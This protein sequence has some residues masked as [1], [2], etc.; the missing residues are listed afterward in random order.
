MLFHKEIASL[1]ILS[2]VVCTVG[3]MLAVHPSW[4][5]VKDIQAARNSSF[6]YSEVS[7]ENF[8]SLLKD[9]KSANMVFVYTLLIPSG[10]ADGMYLDVNAVLLHEVPPIIKVSYLSE[11]GLITS[12]VLAFYLEDFVITLMLKQLL[13][14]LGHSVASVVSF[15]TTMYTCQMIGGIRAS[16]VFSLQMVVMLILQYTLMSSIMPGHHNW[17]EVLGAFIILFGVALQPA[18]DIVQNYHQADSLP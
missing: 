4:I 14:V 12:I 15:F 18:H 13:L 6:E 2:F 10:I 11:F 9:D 7:A 16:L 17:I 3:L 8:I 5:F 1:S